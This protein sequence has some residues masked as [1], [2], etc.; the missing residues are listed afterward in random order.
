MFEF[1]GTDYVKHEAKLV[2]WRP[3]QTV[4]ELTMR[5]DQSCS[6]CGSRAADPR[7]DELSTDEL[8]DV[9]A[10][11]VD[12][13]S[14][15][16]TLIGGEAYL[17]PGMYDVIEFFA[18][19]EIHVALQTGGRSLNDRLA[20]R[21]AD[22]G[23]SAVSVSVDGPRDAHDLLRNNPGSFEYAM[24]ALHAV[25]DLGIR[26]GV[27]TQV[28]ELNADRLHELLPDLLATDIEVWRC[29]LTAPMGRAADRPEWIL[30]PW[31]VV[32][33]LDTL[34]EIQLD[35]AAVA[36]RNGVPLSE[37][38][39]LKIGSNLGYY[40][41][42]EQILRTPIGGYATHY[43]GCSAG[44]TSLGI[45]SDG[46]I[47]GCPSL[48]TAPYQVGNV[49]DLDLREVWKNSPELGFTREERIDELWGFCATCDFKEV[50]QGG[51][52]FMTHT[53]FGRRGNNPFC[54][55]R[56]TQLKKQG[57][58]ESIRQTEQ[59][60]G[61]PYDFGKFE[62]VEEQW[63]DDWRNEPMPDLYNEAP[64]PVA[65]ELSPRNPKAA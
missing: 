40:G 61:V 39:D 24:R 14:R 55:H 36:K 27:N 19:R 56:V 63:N 34:A 43:S 35:L 49:R 60:P 8:L 3:N 15:S 48:P 32:D 33:V 62:I 11:L 50:C 30:R 4:W 54:Y 64:A 45:E 5:C 65:V 21:L 6:H 13:G 52:S 47:K 7:S 20:R 53:T 31:R 37:V 51:C 46:T 58:R 18:E 16:V 44:S 22:A 42:H 17:H 23:I 28:N 10:A 41:P 2:S 57:I 38:L 29:H 59:A 12:I 9:A 25:G 1:F 26:S